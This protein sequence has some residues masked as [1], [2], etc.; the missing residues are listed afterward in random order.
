MCV[1]GGKTGETGRVNVQMYQCADVRIENPMIFRR[2]NNI[3]A[4]ICKELQIAAFAH[5]HIG[6]SAH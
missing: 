3:N 6:K 1:T 2:A 4:A 5:L